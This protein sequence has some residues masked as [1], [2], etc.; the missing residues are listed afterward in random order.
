M[1]V[2]MGGFGGSLPSYILPFLFTMLRDAPVSM[3]IQ[4]HD[5]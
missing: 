3:N 2:I 1:S 5:Y 4:A